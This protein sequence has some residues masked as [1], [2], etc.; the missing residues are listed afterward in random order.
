MVDG[1]GGRVFCYNQPRHVQRYHSQGHPQE[2]TQVDNRKVKPMSTRECVSTV[3]G[4]YKLHRSHGLRNG[5]RLLRDCQRHRCFAVRY[6]SVEREGPPCSFG[7]SFILS[8]IWSTPTTKGGSETG[9]ISWRLTRLRIAAPSQF[10]TAGSAPGLT[11]LRS[12]SIAEQ[13]FLE[14]LPGEEVINLQSLK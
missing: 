6:P 4:R 5:N 3:M 10:G 8:G 11:S 1:W 9:M 2:G 7:G 14:N 12:G 13:Q